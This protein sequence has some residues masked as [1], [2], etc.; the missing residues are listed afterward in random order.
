MFDRFHNGEFIPRAERD[1]AGVLTLYDVTV[2]MSGLYHCRAYN[3][4][5]S[6]ISRKAKLLVERELYAF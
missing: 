3:E 5:G 4:F 1:T 2:N 6:S